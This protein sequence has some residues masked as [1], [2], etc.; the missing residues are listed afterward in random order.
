[1]TKKGVD[2]GSKET[3]NL[4]LFCGGP[5]SNL[6]SEYHLSNGIYVI[7]KAATFS[8][9][10]SLSNLGRPELPGAR[11]VASLSPSVLGSEKVGALPPTENR[12]RIRVAARDVSEWGLTEASASLSPGTPIPARRLRGFSINDPQA[13]ADGKQ[14]FTSDITYRQGCSSLEKKSSQQMCYLQ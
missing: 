3:L 2:L 9:P 13:N 1:M 12:G 10:F 4:C 5:S 11:A 7:N 14:R 6:F 8:C